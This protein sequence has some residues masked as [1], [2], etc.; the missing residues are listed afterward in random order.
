MKK[1]ISILLVVALITMSGCGWNRSKSDRSDSDGR[2]IYRYNDGYY[3]IVADAE[4]G[5][6]YISRGTGGLCVMV[7][8][9]GMP[10]TGGTDHDKD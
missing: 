1:V 2:I 4:T 3:V 10:Y 7:D 8:K 5:V 6:Q 9:N